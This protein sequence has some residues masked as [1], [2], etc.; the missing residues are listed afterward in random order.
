[1]TPTRWILLGIAVGLLAVTGVVYV[2][3]PRTSPPPKYSPL[4]RPQA[5]DEA[6]VYLATTGFDPARGAVQARVRVDTGPAVPAEGVYL[7]SDAAGLESVRVRKDQPVPE[8]SVSIDT[9]AG[10]IADYPFDRYLA[11]AR[12]KAV[13]GAD[14][15]PATLEAATPAPISVFGAATATGVDITAH[16]TETGVGEGT[17]TLEVQRSLAVRAWI[18]A[19]MAIDWLLAAAAVAV[20]VAVVLG[21]RSWESR[22]LAW[23]GAMLFALIAFRNTAPGSPPLGVFLDYYA[24]FPAVA[25]VVLSLLALVV[26][27][28]SRPR[29]SLGL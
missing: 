2:A 3:V 19:M 28:L 13:Q 26:T 1:M 25:L 6:V 8:A 23:L 11:T 9:E 22:H 7:T 4:A 15:T 10:S 21:H 18:V 12:I 16:G 24:F 17:I 20:V 27:F 14:T 29:E 5:T